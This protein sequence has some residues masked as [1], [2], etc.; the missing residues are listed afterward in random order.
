M[1]LDD[2]LWKQPLPNVFTPF[3]SKEIASPKE[4]LFAHKITSDKLPPTYTRL[5]M[6]IPKIQNVTKYTD[7]ELL[8]MPFIQEIQQKVSTGNIDDV[9]ISIPGSKILKG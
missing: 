5:T 8:Q 4:P 3:I 7:E 9:F 6:W 2:Q 1:T